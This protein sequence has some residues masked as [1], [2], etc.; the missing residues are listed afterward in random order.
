M[1]TGCP[2]VTGNCYGTKELAEGAAILVDPESVEDIADGIRR[3]L[4]NDSLRGDLISRGR[5]RSR[6]FEWRRCAAETLQVLERVGSE[7]RPV[8]RRVP[9]PAAASRS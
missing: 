6:E 8:P 5:K 1:A 2:V 7:R 9:G 4:D 3:V